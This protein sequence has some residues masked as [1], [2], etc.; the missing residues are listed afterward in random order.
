M[1][2]SELLIPELQHETKLT[3]TFLKRVPDDKLEWTPHEK[4]MP[5]GKLA[6]HLV[7]MYVW[8]P[9]TMNMDA[10]DLASYQSPQA[11]GSAELI[12]KLHELAPDAEKSLDK[13]DDVYWQTWSMTQGDQVL[14][15][16]P[17]YTVLRSMVLNQFPHHRAQLGVYFRMLDISV[18]ATYGPSADE[19]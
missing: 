14:M 10:L 15:S 4:S 5:L 8:I 2:I 9:S 17:R 6:A 19:Q 11:A 16:M 7:E 18:P 13:E 3:E 1:K 12:S